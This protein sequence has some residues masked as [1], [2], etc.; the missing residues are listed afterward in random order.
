VRTRTA[1]SFYE[2]INEQ[3]KW[4]NVEVEYVVEV[5]VRPQTLDVALDGNMESF[6]TKTVSFPPAKVRFSGSKIFEM[7]AASEDDVKK[8]F[9]AL[10]IGKGWEV[11]LYSGGEY[12]SDGFEGTIEDADVKIVSIEES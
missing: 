9:E 1:Q 11:S 2:K 7:E 6:D 8:M 4:W 5:A 3:K 10:N 12:I